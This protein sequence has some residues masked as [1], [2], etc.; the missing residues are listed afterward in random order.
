MN[1]IKLNRIYPASFL[2]TI[3]TLTGTVFAQC[4]NTA[5]PG[6]FY[7]YYIIAQTGSCNG[8]TFTS[9]GGNPSINDIGQV[10][11]MGQSSAL[12]G[13]ALWIGENRNP[14]NIA[15]MCCDLSRWPRSVRFYRSPFPCCAP[16]TR[17]TNR[18]DSMTL[19][20][21]AMR[22]DSAELLGPDIPELIYRFTQ[23]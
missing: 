22:P 12:S 14:A 6:K 1:A 8:N 5:I 15:L 20:A 19:I 7:E 13:S 21:I 3:F 11:F 9:L 18:L 17:S 23:R 2:A 10:G 4:T 16:I